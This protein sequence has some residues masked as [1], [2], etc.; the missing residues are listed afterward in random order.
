MYFILAKYVLK[1]R[2]AV[3]AGSR[4]TKEK[5]HVA[6]C[7]EG[8]R[9]GTGSP[10]RSMPEALH[11]LLIERGIRSAEEAEAYLRADERC[12]HDPLQLSDMMPAVNRI[13]AALE[14]GETLCVYGDYDV[15]GVCASA[16]LSQ[17]LR[18]KGADGTRI[19]AFPASRGIWSE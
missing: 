14:A 13:K 12:L 10:N 7:S 5:V 11:R 16:I 3:D 17:W 2:A 15:D 1:D 8:A 9:I 18:S 19:P 6:I 4:F